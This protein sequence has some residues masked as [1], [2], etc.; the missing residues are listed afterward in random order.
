MFFIYL[1]KYFNYLVCLF[2]IFSQNS[3]KFSKIGDC[4]LYELEKK[5]IHLKFVVLLV[6]CGSSECIW[7]ETKLLY[8]ANSIVI[9]RVWE[10]FELGKCDNWHKSAQLSIQIFVTNFSLLV[11]SRTSHITFQNRKKNYLWLPY[12]IYN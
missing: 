12:E 11:T 1:Y 9:R 8:T 3:K 2:L 6:F 10:W 7:S 5:G 4:E